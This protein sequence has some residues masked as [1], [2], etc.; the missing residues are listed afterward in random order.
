MKSNEEKRLIK[1]TKRFGFPIYSA[2]KQANDLVIELLKQIP[3][4]KMDQELK[5][6]H[7][8]TPNAYFIER[9]VDTRLFSIMVILATMV[10]VAK[11]IYRRNGIVFPEDDFLSD[12]A[13]SDFLPEQEFMALKDVSGQ[14]D[15][16]DLCL[17]V[18]ERVVEAIESQFFMIRNYNS[19]IEEYSAKYARKHLRIIRMYAFLGINIS[20]VVEGFGF[21]AEAGA[22]RALMHSLV[23]IEGLLMK[24]Q[25]D[26]QDLV[27][28]QI[29]RFH[30]ILEKLTFIGA[31]FLFSDMIG[32]EITAVMKVA[33]GIKYNANLLSD[34]VLLDLPD[35]KKTA[36]PY[37]KYILT[38]QSFKSD[39]EN[40]KNN[41][42]KS[43]GAFFI[44]EGEM[45]GFLIDLNFSKAPFLS[46]DQKLFSLGI[47]YQVS[48]VINDYF[49]EN[50][51]FRDISETPEKESLTREEIY[52]ALHKGNKNFVPALSRFMAM[53]TGKKPSPVS[54][55]SFEE[56]GTGYAN[57]ISPISYLAKIKDGGIKIIS[58]TV[59]KLD[60]EATMEDLLEQYDA[61][62]LDLYV[63]KNVGVCFV[64][65]SDPFFMFFD[66]PVSII[67]ARDTGIES[68]DQ[69]AQKLQSLQVDFHEMVHATQIGS[70]LIWRD[71]F[72]SVA[73]FLCDLAIKYLKEGILD[74]DEI[75]NRRIKGVITKGKTRRQFLIEALRVYIVLSLGEGKLPNDMR[76][77]GL[78]NAIANSDFEIEEDGYINADVLKSIPIEYSTTA[79]LATDTINVLSTSSDI[80]EL[81]KIEETLKDH[82]QE[83]S[84][85]VETMAEVYSLYAMRKF[86]EN[87]P[88][89]RYGENR[90]AEY[91]ISMKSRLERRG[92]QAQIY[93]DLADP[94]YT[95]MGYELNMY[96]AQY[97]M[98]YDQTINNEEDEVPV[99]NHLISLGYDP[100][101][102]M[103]AYDDIGKLNFLAEIESVHPAEIMMPIN[104][105][106]AIIGLRYSAN[107]PLMIDFVKRFGSK[108]AFRMLL[109]IESFDQIEEKLNE[110]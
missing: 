16:E 11:D 87:L 68:T 40:L 25:V 37:E 66:P 15:F 76:K 101:D 61:R 4:D 104:S 43:L 17:A 39:L 49:G 105:A 83:L 65:E 95:V 84:N 92:K 62:F 106:K 26:E 64:M 80:S 63:R 9:L 53:V 6:V 14:V 27:F 8:V 96:L 59:S 7:F 100:L 56:G 98:I 24:M 42:A 52:K 102:P 1:Q 107:I 93:L 78:Y 45:A 2:V 67:E 3:T 32:E 82:M 81:E 90:K 44:T 89:R 5:N 23:S 30:A 85:I 18:M 69:F 103:V 46:L 72:S 54:Y 51:C 20:K 33:R 99:M 36:I 73:V 12:D 22:L 58:E 50:L 79:K 47:P 21:T 88:D 55:A 13:L 91:L 60:C 31:S 35:K 75:T 57:S 70:R 28:E 10:I 41:F 77:N 108:K 48:K 34:L 71:V 38:V 19:R 29:L 74:I 110:K 94:G 86:L 109:E 97:G